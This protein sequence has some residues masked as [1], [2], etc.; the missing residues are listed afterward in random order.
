VIEYVQFKDIEA[1]VWVKLRLEAQAIAVAARRT[2]FKGV[3]I[4]DEARGELALIVKMFIKQ[5]E[6]QL[7]IGV[8][9]SRDLW[10][11]AWAAEAPLAAGLRRI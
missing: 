6:P 2:K 8:G 1:G 3:R 9:D 11:A 5:H 7:R 10:D 4:I